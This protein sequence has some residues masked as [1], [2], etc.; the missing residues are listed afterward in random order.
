MHQVQQAFKIIR[1]VVH[2][3]IPLTKEDLAI[4]D[5]PYFQRLRRIRQTGAQSVYPSANHTRFEHSIGVMHL[6][7]KVLAKLGINVDERLRNTVRYACLLHDIGHA[8]FSHISEVFYPKKELVQ[9]INSNLQEVGLASAP[10]GREAALHELCSCVLALD[11]FG[12]M[13][14]ENQV[15]LELFCRMIIGEKYGSLE[16][17]PEEDGLIDL[18]NSN[19]DVDKLDYVLRDAF[20]SG[21]ELVAIDVER[22]LSAYM[23]EDGRVVFSGKALSTISGLVYGRNALYTWIY[24][25]HITVYTDNLFQRLIRHLINEVTGGRERLFSYEA[26]SESLVDDYDLIAFIRQH[27]EIDDYAQNLY[28][29]LFNRN[30]YKAIWKTVFGFEAA[31]QDPAHR[32]TLVEMVGRFRGEEGG[33]EGLERRIAEV[34]NRLTFGEFYIAAANFKPFVPVND[35]TIYI[36]H[37]SKRQRFQD[38]FHESIYKTPPREI[39]YIFV[40][41][42]NVKDVLLS[43]L[44]GG[45]LL[46]A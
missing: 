6:G 2:G 31:L 15:D 12:K 1:D 23:L 42:Y 4:I 27:K 43:K 38:I 5:T 19:A 11:K 32:D 46:K 44:N 14:L 33:L 20:M 30:Y 35:K 28:D 3:Y 17:R 41:D 7:T 10:V 45:R 26:I 9:R 39:P 34:D 40:K 13:L 36:S 21:A 25:H 24:N 18:L 8:P 22:L 16:D 29:Q 37:G